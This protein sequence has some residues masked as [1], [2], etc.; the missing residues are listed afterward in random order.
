[1]SG[2]GPARESVG[3]E[4]RPGGDGGPEGVISSSETAE[5]NK[6]AS[7]GWDVL[8][9]ANKGPTWSKRRKGG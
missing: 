8:E 7:T 3:G 9:M 4:G 2:I 5:E 1:M 6:E